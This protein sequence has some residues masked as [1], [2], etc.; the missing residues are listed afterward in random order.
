MNIDQIQEQA[1]KGTQA[2]WF[3]MPVD[4]TVLLAMCKELRDT[5]AE[6]E[7]KQLTLDIFKTER[8]IL[9]AENMRHYNRAEESQATN[10]RLRTALEEIMEVLS[11]KGVHR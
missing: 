9:K 6:N 7:A 5:R 4:P 3:T 11:E 8:D 10:D 2:G 1:E